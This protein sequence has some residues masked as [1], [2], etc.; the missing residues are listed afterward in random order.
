MPNLATVLYSATSHKLRYWKSQPCVCYKLAF[1]CDNCEEHAGI[2]ILYKDSVQAIQYMATSM[3]LTP[4]QHCR[5]YD[6]WKYKGLWSA[7][8][9]LHDPKRTLGFYIS[10]DD[11]ATAM[12]KAL[13][14]LVWQLRPVSLSQGCKST[15][16]ILSI[17]QKP[18]CFDIR[19]ACEMTCGK[20]Q[21]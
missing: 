9:Y 14:F 8:L 4:L 10:W 1:E 17:Q 11:A 2:N 19:D 18:A 21:V 16:T 12:D 20:F 3:T 7:C 15:G 5:Q 13:I 6:I